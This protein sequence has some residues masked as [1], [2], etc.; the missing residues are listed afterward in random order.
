MLDADRQFTYS[1]I[2]KL[3]QTQTGSLSL[4]PNPTQNTLYL[5]SLTSGAIIKLYDVTGKTL[6][7]R[8][9]TTTA[10]T[11]NMQAYPKGVYLL[12]YVSGDG[13]EEVKVLRE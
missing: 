7:E 8:T 6:L 9:V 5:E 3:S 1:K 4:Y 13:V 2:V 12:Q 11:I 10:E